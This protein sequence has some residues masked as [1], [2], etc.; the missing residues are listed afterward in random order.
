ME[1]TCC[2]GLLPRVLPAFR[3]PRLEASS[4]A[5]VLGMGG[6][7]DVFAAAAFA[8]LWQ[9]EN[10]RSV[11]L[12]GT[13][14][15]TRPM[16]EDHTPMS[17]HLIRLP[18]KVAPLEPADEGYGSTRLECSVPRG[19]EG[20]P[21]IFVVPRTGKDEGTVEQITAY[22]TAAML[23]SLERLRLDQVLAVDLGGDSLTGGADFER[24]AELGRDRQVLH[25]LSMA[26]L[27]DGF[28]HLIV[29]PGC[30]GETPVPV[31]KA[32]VKAADE[33]GVLLGIMPRLGGALPTMARLSATLRA[34]RTP[35]ILHYAMAHLE[36]VDEALWE[37]GHGLGACGIHRHGNRNEIPWCWLT[38]VLALKGT[39]QLV[40]AR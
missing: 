16:P 6:G 37:D 11:V 10:P 26:P 27:P 33:R 14:T 7:C 15:G 21:L 30:D 18:P 17:A 32:A 3:L 9:T 5:L 8:E 38:V 28:V 39:R 29:G 2:A 23:E 36:G 4:R 24:D 1:R 20:S 19:A 31:M 40:D 13:C 35:N 34:S 25:A 12:F 22:N